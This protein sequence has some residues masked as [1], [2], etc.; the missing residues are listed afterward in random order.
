LVTSDR[1][2]QSACRTGEPFVTLEKLTKTY[3][4]TLANDAIT[5]TIRPGD[6][7]GLVGGN[8]AGKSTLMRMLCGETAPDSGAIF[9]G[10]REVT[11]QYGATAAQGHGIRVVHQELSL[12]GNLSVAENFYLEA[13]RSGFGLPGW[14]RQYRERARAA[15]EAV[16]PNSGI[17]VDRQVGRLP[18]GGRQMVE[19]ARA[20]TAPGARLVVLDEPTSS[21]GLERS[22]QLRAHLHARA[23]EGTAF[24]FI[25]HK[26]HE[27]VDVATRV[28]VMRNGRLVWEGDPE[29]ASVPRLV[30]LMGGGADP[31]AERRAGAARGEPGEVLVRL[32]GP[33]AAE[34][35]GEIAL[36]AGEIVGLAGL[37]GGGQRE[38]LHRVFAPAESRG[39]VLRQGRA[40]F[41][42]GDR[43]REGV[44]PLW[45]VLANI[46]IERIARLW[47][48]MP[49]GRG[50]EETHARPAAEQL[51]LDPGRFR[52][53]ILDLSGG[54]QQKALVARA[55][56]SDAPV[57]LLD[58]P[59]R[60]VDVGAKQDFYATIA[61]LARQGRLVMWYSTEDLEFL[62]CD[63][64]LVFSKGAV[65]EDLRGGDISEQR[66]IDASFRRIE[67]ARAAAERAAPAGGGR[68]AESLVRIAPFVSLAL[69]L[70][71][72]GWA[73]PLSLS[74]FGLD[75]LLSP[76]VPLVLIALGQMFVVGGSEIDL[77]AG[78]FAG[79]VNVVSAT[80]LV[81][82]P[83]AGVPVL[84]GLLLAYAL[85]GA[86][87]QARRIPAIVVTLGASF[88]WLGIGLTLQPTPGGSS[89]DWLTAIFSVSVP[90][91]PT[92]I[93]FIVLMGLVAVLI[94]R[95]PLGVALRGFGNNPQAMVVS[96]WSPVRHAAYRYLISGLFMLAA[97]LALTAI[98]TA[99]DINSGNSFTLLSVAAVVIGGC[100]LLGGIISPIGVVAGAVTL[101]LLGA[102]LGVLSV[103]SNFNPAVQGLLLLAIL[104]FR[105]VL[106]RK[107]E[108][109]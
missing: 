84:V 7:V 2:E 64:V 86:L 67:A 36:R 100:S 24:I 68:L 48:A 99:S 73:N 50:E 22:R 11:G 49:I 44:F 70:A 42:S 102:L 58:D 76:A 106:G 109:E 96:G 20:L 82:A 61:D 53:G 33:V 34:L 98:N 23:A 87:I 69:V 19:I 92:S 31:S 47:S 28:A 65:T 83:A 41:V 89:P 8:G 39:T 40:S 77:G 12:C 27:I 45:N 21:L 94:D 14:R 88:I 29:T 43:Q 4:P 91:I 71:V 90:F 108:F 46:S 16:F 107:D 51:R 103:S 80:L 59:T 37:E 55:L 93:V 95:A 13:P 79:L 30:G 18:I 85:L 10:P 104:A 97:G 17:D 1:L 75:L 54:N 62:E 56:A 74:S 35:G 81:A 25:S 52:S 57:I 15:L 26:L 9:I 78:A 32:A 3:G 72:M 63:R 6:I 101:G 38:T 105:A 60:G 5:L 66:I